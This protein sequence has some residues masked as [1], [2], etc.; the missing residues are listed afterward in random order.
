MESLEKLLKE[1]GA[2]LKGHFQLSSGLHS[3]TY[4]Q[5]ARIFQYP[6]VAERIGEELGKKFQNLNPEVV[7]GPALGGVILSFV[8]ARF[9]EVR[10]IFAERKEGKLELRRGFQIKTGERVL[11]VED[12]VTTALSVKETIELVKQSGGLVIGVGC[13]VDRSEIPLDLPYFHSLLKI[14]IKTYQADDCPLCQQGV[15]FCYPGSRKSGKS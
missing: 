3:D 6:D 8:V 14:S 10:S 15:P 11:V 1:K 12:V 9:L 4:I 7:I 2:V 5:T 13:L